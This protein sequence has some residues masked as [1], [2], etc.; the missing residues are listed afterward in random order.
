MVLESLNSLLGS[1]MPAIHDHIQYK[2]T[3]DLSVLLHTDT[4]FRVHTG[5][6]DAVLASVGSERACSRS[7]RAFNALHSFTA[8]VELTSWITGMPRTAFFLIGGMVCVDCFMYHRS[9]L[10][11][12]HGNSRFKIILN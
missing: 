12:V 3:L 7:Q 11:R 5:T 1:S 10:F 9:H 8:L 4:V 6:Q 2:I